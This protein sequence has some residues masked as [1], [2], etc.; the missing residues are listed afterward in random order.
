MLSAVRGVPAAHLPR[1]ILAGVALAALTIPL[2]IGYAQVAGLPPI[3]GIYAAILPA[4]LFA[5]FADT[6]PWSPALT[7]PLGR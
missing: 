4:I 5:L 6:R 2:N 7:P 1:E 3:V